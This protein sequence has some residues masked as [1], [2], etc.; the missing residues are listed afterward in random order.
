MAA[1]SLVRIRTCSDKFWYLNVLKSF[2]K[3]K[4][5]PGSALIHSSSQKNG[6]HLID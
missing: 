2:C 5:A 3:Y 6:K 4:N 1:S